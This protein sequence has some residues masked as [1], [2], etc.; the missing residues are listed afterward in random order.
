M[1]H[2]IHTCTHKNNNYGNRNYKFITTLTTEIST[3]NVIE[4]VR[5]ETE[6]PGTPCTLCICT[7]SH[8]RW[9][10]QPADMRADILYMHI[11]WSS[12]VCE[13]KT[14]GLQWARSMGVAIMAKKKML[15]CEAHGL[16]WTIWSTLTSVN[17]H[18]FQLICYAYKLL[19]CLDVEIWWF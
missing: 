5:H 1:W 19:R 15:F 9:S 4:T 13:Q 3:D 2:D 11:W 12:C 16:C 18:R 10:T 7:A 17:F 6:Y 8:A 14:H